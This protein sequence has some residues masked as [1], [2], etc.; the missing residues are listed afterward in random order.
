MDF[1]NTPHIQI[2][3]LGKV[4]KY[5][6][7]VLFIYPCPFQSVMYSDVLNVNGMLMSDHVKGTVRRQT[8]IQFL[9]LFAADETDLKAI[10]NFEAGL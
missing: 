1:F 9:P 5:E 10:W 3:F 2:R 8:K 6:L 7:L 4:F